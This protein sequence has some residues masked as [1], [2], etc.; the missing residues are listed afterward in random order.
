MASRWNSVWDQRECDVISD[1]HCPRSVVTI[2]MFRT[3]YWRW[4]MLTWHWT[5]QV[6]LTLVWF[7]FYRG[8][9][10]ST[11]RFH[12]RHGMD[13]CVNVHVAHMMYVITRNS[14]STSSSQPSKHKKHFYNIRTMLDQRRRSWPDVVQMLWKCFCLL[15]GCETRK[16]W[17]RYTL[18]VQPLSLAYLYT[19]RGVSNVKLS[20]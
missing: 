10:A 4:K 7:I 3:F 17:F 20:F 6:M 16:L 15:R 12:Q 11:I 1:Y 8:F 19:I 14:Q 13:D 9:L 18:L 5:K 2:S